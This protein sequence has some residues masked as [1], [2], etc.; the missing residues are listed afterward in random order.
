[1]ATKYSWKFKPKMRAR[2]YG[3]QGSR[4]AMARLKESV[5]EIKAIA[6]KD[7]VLA[8]EGVRADAGRHGKRDAISPSGCDKDRCHWMGEAIGSPVAGSPA[9]GRCRVSAGRGKSVA[10]L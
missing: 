8:G 10:E 1:M 7:P 2:S 5:S 3:W 9:S 4:K 6:R